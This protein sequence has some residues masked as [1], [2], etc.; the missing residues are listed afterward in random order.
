MKTSILGSTLLICLFVQGMFAQDHPETEIS[1]KLIHAVVMLPD[2]DH[3]SYQATRFDWSGIISSLDYAGHNYIAKWQKL[4]DPKINDAITG[5]A[6]EF[7]ASLGYDKAKAGGTFVR[8]G[9]GIVRKPDDG[10]YQRFKTYDIVNHGEWTVR[11]GK[12]WIRFTQKLTSGD[13]YAYVYQKTL[14]LEKGK[15][16]LLIS[17][18]LKNTGRKTIDTEVYSHNFFVIDHE[19]VGPDIVIRFSFVPKPESELQHGAEVRGRTIT[20]MR[21]LQKGESASTVLDGF[22]EGLRGYNMR[23]ENEKSGAGVEI[24]GNQPLTKVVFWSIPTVACPEN[25]I[26]LNIPPGKGASWNTTFNFY[27][28]TPRNN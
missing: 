14:R 20:Y 11:K 8:I 24:S 22:G 17:H 19:V 23:I 2:A 28:I 7:I 16:E 12:N 5:P 6:E 25:Y 1:N 26:H 10:A 3:G 13:G 21:I 4:T 15:P 27:T 18:S 9:V